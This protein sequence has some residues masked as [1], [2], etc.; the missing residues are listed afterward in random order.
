MLSVL[1]ENVLDTARKLNERDAKVAA[2]EL[3]KDQCSS[4]EEYWSQ[5]GSGADGLRGKDGQRI[6]AGG[7][8]F[9]YG[10]YP[11]NRRI[12][13]DVALSAGWTLEQA[14]ELE[15]FCVSLAAKHYYD[16]EHDYK[17]CEHERWEI[18]DIANPVKLGKPFTA[19]HI[20]W[21]FLKSAIKQQVEYMDSEK[22][23]AVRAGVFD[24]YETNSKIG[25][26]KL[27]AT[28]AGKKRKSTDVPCDEDIVK[29]QDEID[30]EKRYVEAVRCSIRSGHKEPAL[31][32]QQIKAYMASHD[33]T[34]VKLCQEIGVRSVDFELFLAMKKKDEM[35][36]SVAYHAA[37][38]FLG[39]PDLN[40]LLEKENLPPS[41]RRLEA[42]EVRNATRRQRRCR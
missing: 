33:L 25:K 24:M 21:W 11:R 42:D 17:H 14:Q 4:D 36:R 9:S 34:Q 40:E 15:Q 7:S 13:A 38:K 1:N 12:L 19:Q 41:Y 6:T 10:P 26:K 29:A 30:Q 3:K 28:V 5:P 20:A 35:Y 23:A 2:G 27:P 31:V 37:K 8:K 22:A 39:A 16:V 18:S 32:K